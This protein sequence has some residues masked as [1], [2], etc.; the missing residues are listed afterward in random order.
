MD[1]SAY[2]DALRIADEYVKKQKAVQADAGA[3]TTSMVKQLY[4][5]YYEVGETWEVAAVHIDSSQMRRTGDPAQLRDREDR[6]GLFRYE[7]KKVTGGAKPEVLVHV[8]QLARDGLRPIDAKIST[9]VIKV[10]DQLRENDKTYVTAG[11]A[12]MVMAGNTGALKSRATPLELYPL[13][14]PDVVTADHATAASLPE[15][16][17]SLR[18]LAARAGWHPDLGRSTWFDQSDFFGRPLQFLW[19]QG[20]PWPTYLK[21]PNGVAILIRKGGN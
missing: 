21:T 9:V 3:L 7:V 6:V 11:P 10:D 14:V 13:D 1:Q 4:G 18:A 5:R 19:Q 17:A 20:D 8:T 12:A 2:R 16:P 15:L